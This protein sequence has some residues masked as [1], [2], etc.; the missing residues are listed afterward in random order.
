M[1]IDQMR[2]SFFSHLYVIEIIFL[3][4]LSLAA[5]ELHIYLCVSKQECLIAVIRVFFLF[6]AFV[7]PSGT[8]HTTSV[9]IV[10]LW[11]VY[12]TSLTL[13]SSLLPVNVTILQNDDFRV[14]LLIDWVL[15]YGVY[16]NGKKV[17]CT[18]TCIEKD[19]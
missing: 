9:C 8:I 1:I 16:I 17:I 4:L 5:H 18:M 19:E 6:L 2:F 15:F 13:H 12:L 10:N 11:W 3:F 7:I 14:H